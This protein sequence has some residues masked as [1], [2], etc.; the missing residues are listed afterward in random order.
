LIKYWKIR[1]NCRYCLVNP[2]PG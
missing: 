1:S 2:R